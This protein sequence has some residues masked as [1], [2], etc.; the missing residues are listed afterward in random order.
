M[1]VNEAKFSPQSG[2]FEHFAHFRGNSSQVPFHE[3]FTH[4]IKCFQ[5]R[6]IVSN[7]V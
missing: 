2:F 7:R 6:P 3:A 4:K 1:K 5:S